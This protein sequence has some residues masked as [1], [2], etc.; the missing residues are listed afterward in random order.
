[1]FLERTYLFQ[2]MSKEFMEEISRSLVEQSYEKGS[3]PFH[4]GE[5]A[6]YLF[7]L[8]DGRVRLSVGDHGVVTHLVSESG[9]A[10]DW[11]GLVGRDCYMT[12]AECLT[13][14]KVIKVGRERLEEIFQK[15]PASG[16]ILFR[17]LSRLISQRL[18]DTYRMIPSAHGGKAPVAI[19]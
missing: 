2:D 15:D 14:T 13:P 6:H 18:V 3:Q 7:I 1:M 12:T 5:H 4:H 17:H 9:D 19:P 16:Y 8:Q 11:A 10:L